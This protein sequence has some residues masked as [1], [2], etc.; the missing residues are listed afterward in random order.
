M[1][2][3]YKTILYCT[4]VGPNSPY[5][6]RHALALARSLGAKI[7][8][9][10][11]V[12]TLSR[13]QEALVEGYTGAGTLHTVVE[14][15]ERSAAARLRKRIEAFCSR[16]LGAAGCDGLVADILVVE[17]HAVEQI[18]KHVEKLGVDL[19]VMGAHAEST[20]LENLMGT[21]AEK[22]IRSSPVPVVVVQVPTGMQDPDI[23]RI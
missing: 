15:E 12:E 13:A 5:V 22:V 10:H 11:V 1:L 18:L 8:V 7:H 3:T 6:F 4:Q 2:P 17:G 21:A 23:G 20:L 19:V 9:L 16:D 14:R